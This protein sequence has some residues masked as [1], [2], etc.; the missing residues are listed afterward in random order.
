MNN[1][2]DHEQTV[3]AFI[4]FNSTYNK[5]FLEEMHESQSYRF[6]YKIFPCLNKK[7]YF[8]YEY[9]DENNNT[10]KSMASISQAPEPEDIMWTNQGQSS[11]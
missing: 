8:H 10:I 6:L 11:C 7:K 3:P 5:E 2:D 9:Q 1:K 4:T